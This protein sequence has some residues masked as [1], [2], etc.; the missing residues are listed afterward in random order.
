[1]YLIL[2]LKGTTDIDFDR[3]LLT[4]LNLMRLFYVFIIGKV[5]F[6]ERS[7]SHSE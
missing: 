7:E 4:R 6:T 3:K 1:M 2:M 5:N